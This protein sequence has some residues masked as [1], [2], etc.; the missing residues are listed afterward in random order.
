M[1]T[2]PVTVAFARLA[3]SA[4]TTAPSAA[5]PTARE[6]ALL[7]AARTGNRDAFGE[8]VTLHE[9][10][11]FTTTLAALGNSEEAE[12]AAQD[13]FVIAWQKLP[14]FR[15]EASFRT[16]L[17]TIAWRK[18][19]DRRRKRHLWWTRVAPPPVDGPAP[20]DLLVEPAR[21]PEER[22]VSADLLR[23]TRAEILRLS[24]KLRDALLLACSGVHTYDE[25]G[26]MLAIP[27]GTVKWRVA[28]ARRVLSVRLADGKPP[29]GPS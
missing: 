9:R 2:V 21:D 20:V 22:A 18:A 5:G 15:G 6:G 7:E 3:P 23:R 17:L 27:V 16:W 13:A 19:L 11:V 10:S 28:E 4:S 25:I 29:K 24:P 8:L 12:D 14:G 26:A 1:S